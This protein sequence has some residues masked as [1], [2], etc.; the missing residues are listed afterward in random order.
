MSLR[1]LLFAALA[2]AAGMRE[3]E[4]D[5]RAL[6]DVGSVFDRLAGDCPK[7]EG[8]RSSLLFAVNQEYARPDSPVRDGD[9]I[10]FFPPVSGG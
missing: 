8:Y 9:E 3:I 5:A 10:A 6:P 7:L 4:L 2:E 1:V